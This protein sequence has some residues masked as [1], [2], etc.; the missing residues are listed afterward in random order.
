MTAIAVVVLGAAIVGLAANVF[1]HPRLQ[2]ANAKYGVQDAK[3]D[4]WAGSVLGPSLT[5]LALFLAF[6]IADASGS[7]ASAKS[8]AQ[9]E[10]TVIERVYRTAGF[11]EEPYRR[12]LQRSALCYSR[13]VAGP[14]WKAMADGGQSTIPVEWTGTGHNG[15]RR[16]FREMGADHVLFGKLTVADQA[17]AD[18]RR[19]RLTQAARRSPTRSSCSSSRL[20]PRSCCFTRSPLPRAA[21]CTSSRRSSPS[22]RCLRRSASSTRS[23]ARSR[24]PSRSSPRTCAT[25]RRPSARTSWVTTAPSA[26]AASGRL[27]IEPTQMQIT[28]EMIRGEFIERYGEDRLGCDKRGNPTKTS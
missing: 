2:R 13:A 11:L 15:M 4:S 27:A 19:T 12:R 8:A 26:C 14:E 25:P 20:S 16:A 5:L 17:R 10:S 7:F 3:S 6:V 28:E 23:I 18:A 22:G 21:C 9:S 1:L 24:V